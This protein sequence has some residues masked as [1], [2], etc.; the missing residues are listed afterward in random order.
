MNVDDVLFCQ[1]LLQ[2]R[3]EVVLTASGITPTKWW[4]IKFF[5]ALQVIDVQTPLEMENI[6]KSKVLIVLTYP[7]TP[8]NKD[9]DNKKHDES[10]LSR[11]LQVYFW[12]S[13]VQ[14]HHETGHWDFL[15]A[16]AFQRCERSH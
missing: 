10:N 3:Y 11:T 5:F 7:H 9:E 16:V 4:Q 2:Q 14:W 12:F 6:P 15:S 1:Q 13:I 8:S